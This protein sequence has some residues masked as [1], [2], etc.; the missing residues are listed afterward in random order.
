MSIG[1]RLTPKKGVVDH[2]P[3]IA[4]IMSGLPKWLTWYDYALLAV[5]CADQAGLSLDNQARLLQILN[6][7]FVEDDEDDE[8]P[9]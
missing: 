6:A 8:E 4:A 3:E 9:K 7:T 2:D 5:A 1:D